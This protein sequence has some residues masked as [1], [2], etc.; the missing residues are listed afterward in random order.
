MTQLR[1]DKV[2]GSNSNLAPILNLKC[3]FAKDN[4]KETLPMNYCT[5]VKAKLKQQPVLQLTKFQTMKLKYHLS[6]Y[7][8]THTIQ[9]PNFKTLS[10]TETAAHFANLQS[11][12]TN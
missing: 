2:I 6:H 4:T 10:E 3:D 12:L 5:L 9:Y 7:T 8:E 1:S 11:F